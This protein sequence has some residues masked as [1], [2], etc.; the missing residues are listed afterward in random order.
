M[1][2]CTSKIIVQHPYKWY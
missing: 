2:V 1:T